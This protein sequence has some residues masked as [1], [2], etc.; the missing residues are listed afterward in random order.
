MMARS[1]DCGSDEYALAAIVQT[2]EHHRRLLNQR[3]TLGVAD[4]RLLWLLQDNRPRSLREIAGALGLEQSTVN[5]QVNGAVLEGLVRREREPGHSTYLFSQTPAGSAAFE[6]N[7]ALGL[8]A[9]SQAL[10]AFTPDERPRVLEL[11]RRL[12]DA[13]GEAVNRGEDTDLALKAPRALS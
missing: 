7:V 9:Y 10:S 11:L 8:D 13:Y 6:S 5:R 4:M 12:V 1:L 2:L 3:A